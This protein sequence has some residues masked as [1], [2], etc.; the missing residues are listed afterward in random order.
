[1]KVLIVDDHAYNRE[2]L[3]YVLEDEGIESLQAFD[4]QQAIDVFLSN[5]DI[6][7]ILMDIN[8]PVMDGIDATRRIKEYASSRL[9]TIIFVTA[10]DDPEIL[11]KCLDAGGDDFV[12]KPIN[13]AILVSRLRAHIRNQ[14]IYKGLKSANDKLRYHQKIMDREHQVVEHIFRNNSESVDT[15][16]QN[17]TLYTSPASLFNGDILLSAPSPS[18][19]VYLLVGD[20]TG[21]GLSAA[22][23]SLPVSS[24]FYDCAAKQESIA[25]MAA[26]MNRRLLKLLPSEMFFCAA[27]VYID[28]TGQSM[29]FW[30]GG[31]NDI[32]CKVPGKPSLLKISAQH[33]PMGILQEDEF[34]NTIELHQLP[35]SSRLYIFTD[36]VNEA[37]NQKAE[38]FGLETLEKIVLYDD[39]PIDSVIQAVRKFTR[40]VEQDDDISIAEV[41][42]EEIIHYDL[43]GQR[44]EISESHMQ[45]KSFPWRLD[46]VLQASDLRATDLVYQVSQLL[47]SIQGIELH[48]DK[49]F[50]IIS[51]LYSNALEHGVLKLSSNLKSTPDGFDEYYHLR[52]KRLAALSHE[53]IHVMLEYFQANDGLQKSTDQLGQ[54][55]IVITDSGDGFDYAAHKIQHNN[56]ERYGRGISLLESF[57]ESLSYS[58]GG[59]TATA[60]YTLNPLPHLPLK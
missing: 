2:L 7:L 10:L 36:G 3:T 28:P 55:K 1:M 11:V 14:E 24:I 31:M 38:E 32:L 56:N 53:S 42:C 59:R 48:R 26:Q 23:G 6:E 9:V 44:I 49:I 34:N 25:Y 21:H 37:K 15:V 17:I 54:L 35:P 13:E 45:A 50:T 58:N 27:L 47:G 60:I 52:R 40:N 5:S 46:M 41:L 12:P 29:Q 20:F 39:H 8:M 22:L 19:G 51:E 18:G 57:C 16:C 30:V 4:G 33:M 43:D